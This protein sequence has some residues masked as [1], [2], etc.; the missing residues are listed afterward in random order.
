MYSVKNHRKYAIVAAYDES[1]KRQYKSRFYYFLNKSDKYSDSSCSHGK[2]FNQGR[3]RSTE[4]TK[5]LRKTGSRENTMAASETTEVNNYQALCYDLLSVVAKWQT[6]SLLQATWHWK[7]KQIPF[8]RIN[9][10]ILMKI[11]DK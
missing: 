4:E 8:P 2:T 6:I 1:F 9:E 5:Q 7:D 10:P 11:Y 3:P